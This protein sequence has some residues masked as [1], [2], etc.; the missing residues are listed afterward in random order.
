[1]V[2]GN[3]LAA[4]S[5]GKAYELWQ[6]DATG[7]HALRLLDKAGGGQVRRVIAVSGSTTKWAVT[8]E[9]DGGVDAPTGDAIFTGSA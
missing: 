6:I 3:G 2:I 1:V 9:P 5:A 4:P 8:V 7:P